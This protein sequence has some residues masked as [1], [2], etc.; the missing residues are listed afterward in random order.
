LTIFPKT[1][2]ANP[3]SR[4][5]E[6]RIETTEL[7]TQQPGV[8]PTR[9]RYFLTIVLIAFLACTLFG[10]AFMAA[11]AF[12]VQ[13]LAQYWAAAHLV[14]QNPYSPQLV[15][16]FEKSN[17][18]ALMTQPLVIKNP[19]WAITL[20]LPL[21]LLNYQASFAAWTVMSIIVVAGCARASWSLANSNPSLAPALLSLLFGPTIVSLMLGQFTVLVLLGVTLFLIL[22][23]HKRDWL[24]GASLLLVLGKP[25]VAFVF[26]VAV[27]LW[28]VKS[29][30][31]SILLSGA[32]SLAAACIPVFAI[33]PHIFGQFLQR[34]ELVVK[35]TESY[36]NLGGMLYSVS[37]NHFL[38]LL[39]QCLAI[40]WLFVYWK[41]HHAEWDWKTHGMVVLLVSVAC[42]YYSYPYDEIL[43]LPPLITAFAMGNRR[44]FLAGFLAVNLGYAVYISNVAGHYGFDYMFLW[45]TAS[46]WLIT[47]LLAIKVRPQSNR[48]L[49]QG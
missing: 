29:R 26:L 44:I 49:D 4:I 34:A 6:P 27:L 24:A 38:A 1:G 43:M 15:S 28:A 22:T 10:A 9:S 32:V 36:P 8:R 18:I 11:G 12:R 33:N 45:W 41:K 42:S 39:P 13:D 37:G 40:I 48:V 5:A 3:T 16:E 19:P 30:R 23:Q 17:G 46:A 25:H 35:E 2:E 20:L 7:R 21:G 47:Y 14:S 31:L